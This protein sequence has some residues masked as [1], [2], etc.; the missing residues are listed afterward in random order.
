MTIKRST[1]FLNTIIGDCSARQAIGGG[2][3]VLY[4]GTEPATADAAITGQVLGYLSDGGAAWTAETRAQWQVTLSGTIGG[5]ISSFKVINGPLAAAGVELLAASITPAT[6][7]TTTAALVAAA[8][9]NNTTYP[10]FNAT[11][12]GA[13]ITLYAPIGSGTRFNASTIT[14]TA[15]TI[16]ATAASSGAATTAGVAAANGID[17]SV[18]PASGSTTSSETWSGS[19]ILAGTPTHFRVVTDASDTG[20]LS[21]TLR[22]MQGSVG[23]TG[24]GADLTLSTTTFVT[25]PSATPISVTSGKLSGS[26]T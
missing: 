2:R 24:S 12:S 15:V 16:T 4:S 18:A 8:I 7:L 17:F 6:D 14:V 25:T 20:Q 19:A 21:T 10:N 26:A 9:N 22:R 23:L 5:S 3:I 13:V 1:G 11:S